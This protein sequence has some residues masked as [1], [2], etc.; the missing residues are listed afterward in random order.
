MA[1]T[2]REVIER[3]LKQAESAVKSAQ[4][5]VDELKQLVGQVEDPRQVVLPGTKNHGGGK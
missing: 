2:V 4:K 5:R 3:Q 1:A